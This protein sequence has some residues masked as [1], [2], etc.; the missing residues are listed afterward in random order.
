MSSKRGWKVAI[1]YTRPRNHGF[2]VWL[3]PETKGYTWCVWRQKPGPKRKI[4]TSGKH[5]ELSQ[6]A[7]QAAAQNAIE[8]DR[9][10]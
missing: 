5:E 9:N 8:H 4:A 3:N 10:H 7:A 2:M 1:P 6:R